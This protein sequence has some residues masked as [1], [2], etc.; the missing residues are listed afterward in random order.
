VGASSNNSFGRVD[1]G[2]TQFQNYEQTAYND[3]N[4]VR[5]NQD[6]LLS[7]QSAQSEN[8]IDF[9]PDMQVSSSNQHELVQNFLSS[10]NILS[11]DVAPTVYSQRSRNQVPNGTNYRQRVAVSPIMADADMHRRYNAMNR[12]TCGMPPR[13]GNNQSVRHSLDNVTHYS[14]NGMVGYP[15]NI[16]SEISFQN[17]SPANLSG[18]S[19]HLSSNQDQRTVVSKHLVDAS[20]LTNTSFFLADRRP[21]S[22][23]VPAYVDSHRTEPIL[24]QSHAANTSRPIGVTRP[25]L[26]NQS[27][28]PNANTE[29]LQFSSS[30][31]VFNGYTDNVFQSGG[32][33][34]PNFW[35]S[36]SSP[37]NVPTFAVTG[38]QTGRLQAR[39]NT[40]ISPGSGAVGNRSQICSGNG[41]ASMRSPLEQGNMPQVNYNNGSNTAQ[42]VRLKARLNT[43]QPLVQYPP[44]SIV[45]Y[46]Q[47]S[48]VTFA[49]QPGVRKTRAK[50]PRGTNRVSPASNPRPPRFPQAVPPNSVDM[51]PAGSRR[52][53]KPRNAQP[54]I[55]QE[56]SDRTFCDPRQGGELRNSE[57]QTM[58]ATLRIPGGLPRS[59]LINESN[60]M[61][62]RNVTGVK[63]DS[64]Q[65]GSAYLDDATFAL[66]SADRQSIS[67]PVLSR[68]NNVNML[69]TASVS[70]NLAV[71]TSS[72]SMPVRHSPAKSDMLPTGVIVPIRGHSNSQVTSNIDRSC[73]AFI[74]SGREESL[75]EVEESVFN[76]IRPCR[77]VSGNTN[78]QKP[79]SS[80]SVLQS[81]GKTVERNFHQNE[82][83]SN[84]FS[85]VLNNSIEKVLTSKNEPH[86]NTEQTLSTW[87]ETVMNEENSRGHYIP[88]ESHAQRNHWPMH[89]QQGNMSA[90]NN[91][92]Q[93]ISTARSKSIKFDA[94]VTPT[95]PN[96]RDPGCNIGSVEPMNGLNVSYDSYL[97]QKPTLKYRAGKIMSTVRSCVESKP[98]PGVIRSSL[99]PQRR[100]V[101]AVP[102]RMSSAEGKERSRDSVLV[103]APPKTTL[104]SYESFMTEFAGVTSVM[105]CMS[106]YENEISEIKPEVGNKISLS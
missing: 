17:S 77:V 63:S 2:V 31:R 58:C 22:V 40:M 93:T 100:K 64:V 6:W 90:L 45:Q 49:P 92:R 97:H 59:R 51:T 102:K 85:L 13:L 20:Q 60:E 75:V 70:R 21:A 14:N 53:R 78:E 50:S 32:V 94:E 82:I 104:F 44:P 18:E 106:G 46:Q 30:G 87:R 7:R 48:D 1:I 89:V 33:R 24:Q 72:M 15:V 69:R 4:A 73:T 5:Q 101:Q 36:M 25:K 95:L 42:C 61:F 26:Q 38:I 84:K 80:Q 23:N 68:Q 99:K 76:N 83:A 103:D 54:R 9:I 43:S 96:Q 28:T 57:N 47:F 56:C 19:S 37:V 10:S 55:R 52:P 34:K 16:D 67:I 8:V 88:H 62:S 39:P 91:K 74:S 79:E 3:S 71:S 35:N 81:F 105:N 27:W 98:L 12:E 29:N 11:S 41:F 65:P 86:T 66:S